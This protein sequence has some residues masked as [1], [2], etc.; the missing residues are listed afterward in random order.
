MVA[1]RSCHGSS[2]QEIRNKN[3]GN[4]IDGNWFWSPWLVGL[5]L[6]Q[7]KTMFGVQWSTGTSLR[8]LCPVLMVDGQRQQPQPKKVIDTRV[9]TLSWGSRSSYKSECLNQKMCWLKWEESKWVLAEGNNGYQLQLHITRAVPVQVHPFN[10]GNKSHPKTCNS[11][12]RCMI[13]L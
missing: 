3:R 8:A 12:P 11:Y 10:P 6:P 5:L 7:R 2:Y 13:L 9:W 4:H 1:T